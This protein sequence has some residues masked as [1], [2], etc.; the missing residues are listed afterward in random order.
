VGGEE[1]LVAKTRMLVGLAF[2][3]FG[4]KADGQVAVRFA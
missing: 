4:E 3:S 1:A 2:E